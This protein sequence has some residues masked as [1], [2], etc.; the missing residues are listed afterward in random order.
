MKNWVPISPT[1]FGLRNSPGSFAPLEE[2]TE[3]ESS[4]QE[5][6]TAD[7]AAD[8]WALD[9]SKTL[10]SC[11][12]YVLLRKPGFK[13]LIKSLRKILGINLLDRLISAIAFVRSMH[14][15]TEG[16]PDLEIEPGLIDSGILRMRQCHLTFSM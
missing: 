12:T 6:D 9:K 16:L 2:L 1:A 3:I 13:N 8:G 4:V 5:L 7:C 15:Y 11:L 14:F 10:I